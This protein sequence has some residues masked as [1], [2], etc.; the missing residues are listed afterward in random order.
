ML[1]AAELVEITEYVGVP[2]LPT[3]VE[4]AGKVA[5][6]R[7]RIQNLHKQRRWPWAV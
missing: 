4:D 6:C 7:G 2:V 1:F 5:M 3:R